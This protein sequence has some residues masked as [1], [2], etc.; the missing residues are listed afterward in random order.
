[1][2][3]SHRTITLAGAAALALT[4]AACGSDDTSDS[5]AGSDSAA[6][7]G[8]VT[9]GFI[10]SWTDGL[11]TAYLLEDQLTAMG[12]TVE[13]EELTEPAPLY[14]GLAAGDVDI[15]PSAWPEVT[16]ASYMEE[17]GDQIDDLGAY[18]DNAKLTLAVPSYVDIN[19]IEDLKGNSA[20]FDGTVYGIEAGAGLTKATQEQVFP[21][22]ELGDEG[23]Q[24]VTSSTPAMLAELKK[25]A[26][27]E[28]DIVVTLWRPFW[29]NSEF[30][31]K[32]LEDPKGALGESEALHFLATQGFADECPQAAELIENIKLTD[33]QYG[34]LEDK[35]VN[36][37]GDGREAEAVD[38]WLEEYPDAM[39]AAAAQ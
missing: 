20:K 7:C 33:E 37:F 39:P 28:D 22:Y 34:A 5:A 1:M 23:Y 2:S 8:T 38:A 32:D 19:S 14:A 36:E 9:M 27:A 6:S 18:Y 10:P 11:S 13:M 35:V 25:A 30:D 24:L 12:V 4:L 26:S 3:R 21:Q 15:Y 16:H 29:A 17:Y 31:M